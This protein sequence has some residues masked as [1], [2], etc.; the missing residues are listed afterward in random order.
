MGA[1]QHIAEPLDVHYMRFFYEAL[2][3]IGVTEAQRDAALRSAEAKRQRYLGQDI[4]MVAMQTFAR[5]LAEEV[6]DPYLG[7]RLGAAMANGANGVVE[8]TMLTAPTLRAMQS[9]YA[10]FSPLLAEYVTYGLHE[11]EDKSAVQFRAPHGVQLDRVVEDF[12][13]VR[14]VTGIRRAILELGY[15]PRAVHF[16]YPRPADLAPYQ[17]VFGND[18]TLRFEC[19]C[20]AVV[21]PR[22]LLDAPLPTA[23][24]A[25]HAILLDCAER[26]RTESQPPAKLTT[27]VHQLLIANLRDG[28]PSLAAIAAQLNISERTL[29]RHLAE[30][31]TSFGALLDDVRARLSEVLSKSCDS[32]GKSIA[33]KLGFE[34]ASALRRAQKRWRDGARTA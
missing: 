9:I 2:A 11:H 8:Y 13:L 3:A 1:P 22:A 28:R 7:L 32:S 25:L 16:S 29:R 12:R 20:P 15:S 21:L 31:G 23:D 10:R 6:R 5:T 18:V 4:G 14:I 17:H 34:S 27:R 26:L 24:A 19:D 33:S 30:E